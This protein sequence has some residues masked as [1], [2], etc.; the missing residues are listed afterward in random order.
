M[1]LVNQKQFCVSL[2]NRVAMVMRLSVMF[3]LF[4]ISFFAEA[5]DI[6][7]VMR[8]SAML[9]REKVTLSDVAHITTNDR[10]TLEKLVNLSIGQA[11]KFGQTFKLERRV[12]ERWVKR[13]LGKQTIPTYW[14]GATITIIT[15]ASQKIDNA[16][17]IEV[18]KQKLTDW[19]QQNE[20]SFL[21]T[22]N[23]ISESFIVPQGRLSLLPQD[24][25]K[26]FEPKT[27]TII[28]I[29]I[30]VDDQYIRTISVNLDVGIYRN[31]LVANKDKFQG[32]ILTADDFQ[33]EKILV[34]KSTPKNVLATNQNTRL[35]VKNKILKGSILTSQHVAPIPLIQRGQWVTLKAKSGMLEVESQVQ[36]LR[37]GFIGDLIPVRGKNTLGIVMAK[38]VGENHL[39]LML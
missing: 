11:P 39:E 31:M 22:E 1:K 8:E 35:K 10:D 32:D 28:P 37:P 12:L 27:Q 21:V 3:G 24:L 17:L 25:P 29:D 15:R 9:E 16:L 4:S 18:A 19:L 2:K 33:I 38:I 30:H 14:G 7:I 23:N 36:T 20:S 6:Q 34:D 26:N 13:S 5:F